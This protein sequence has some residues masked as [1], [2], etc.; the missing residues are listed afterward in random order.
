MSRTNPSKSER[1]QSA[2]AK[3][4]EMRR[5][6]EARSRRNRNIIVG[7]TVLVVAAVFVVVA[8]AW[9]SA[10][11]EAAKNAAGPPGL[12]EHKGIIVGEDSA[13]VVVTAY[14]DFM[15]PACGQF[16]QENT[17]QL[18]QLREE[19][20]IKVEYVP[21]SIL[22]RFS[23]GTQ[24]STRAAGAAFC[25]ADTDRDKY[26][27]FSEAMFANQPQENSTGLNNDKI[28]EL[29]AGA[30]V[31][32]AGQTCIKN[33]TYNKFATAVTDQASK[34]GLQGT[35]YVLVDGKPVEDWSAANMKAIIDTAV[36]G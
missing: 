31:S 6:A 29:A 26:V 33:G 27:A 14:T 35:P 10:N 34:D 19:G 18:D 17:A 5:Q 22:D 9:Q 1:N 24:F 21:V 20:K 3:A 32:E 28:A 13:P 2:R 36:A 7:V 25:V 16:E 12:S 8:I 11:R 4:E 23:Q 30:G 15:C